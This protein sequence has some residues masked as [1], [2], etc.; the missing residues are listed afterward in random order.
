MLARKGAK[1]VIYDQM[2]APQPVG[3]GFVLQPTGAA[4]IEAMGLLAEVQKRG[5][6]IS[7]MHGKL[8]RR[9]RPFWR[10]PIGPGMRHRDPTRALFDILLKEAT[11]AVSP[12]RPLAV[13]KTSRAEQGPPL[14]WTR[15][16]QRRIWLST[17][18]V[19]ALRSVMTPKGTGLRRPLGHSALD[20]R[21]S[22]FHPAELEQRYERAA[23]MAGVLP[24][25]TAKD[26]APRMATFFWS[27]RNQDFDIW[28]RAA[29]KLGWMMSQ[30]CGQKRFALP[31]WLSL[32]MPAIGITPDRR[33]PGRMSSGLAMPGMRP[34]RNLGKGPT[35][36]CWMPPRLR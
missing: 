23:R 18:W 5:A 26:G 36:R 10:Y 31:R 28:K 1:L 3:S 27:I 21:W 11:D 35:W 19:R 8:A 12:S 16:P 9:T 29:A 33:L 25:G 4:V 15:E 14:C 7:R 2:P 34:A 22:V 24:V 17:R 13:S 20:R 6:K 32:F 30:D